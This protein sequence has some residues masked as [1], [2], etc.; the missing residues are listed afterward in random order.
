[1]L[2]LTYYENVC[3]LLYTFLLYIPIF[4]YVSFVVVREAIAMTIRIE[5]WDV[6]E[7]LNYTNFSQQSIRSFGKKLKFEFKIPTY[8]RLSATIII[9][10]T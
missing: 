4:L 1:M 3:F 8:F 5:S 6:S 2:M 9:W 7:P 10:F